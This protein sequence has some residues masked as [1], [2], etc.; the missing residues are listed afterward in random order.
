MKSWIFNC[1]ESF[2]FNDVARLSSSLQ[3]FQYWLMMILSCS[4]IIF[5]KL[6]YRLHGKKVLICMQ[7]MSSRIQSSSPSPFLF[8]FSIFHNLISTF[9][10]S[11][12][13]AIS[14]NLQFG[15]GALKS[16]FCCPPTPPLPPRSLASSKD[17]VTRA[18]LN[19]CSNSNLLISCNE[20][21]NHNRVTGV[22]SRAVENRWNWRFNEWT[23]N[24]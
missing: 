22:D 10:S 14:D 18:E 17:V 5:E 21:L 9:F 11:T 15:Y 16:F 23:N 8:S 3:T 19:V 24:H 4:H 7:R 12:I 13:P 2:G 1:L 6:S 20:F